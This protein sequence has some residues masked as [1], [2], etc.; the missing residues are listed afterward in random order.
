MDIIV[1]R[2]RLVMPPPTGAFIFTTVRLHY[3]FASVAA[4]SCSLH[5][6]NTTLSSW[7]SDF[8]FIIFGTGKLYC[9]YFASFATS[10]TS[11]SRHAMPCYFT[12]TSSSPI[13]RISTWT[14]STHIFNQAITI[15][16]Q[17]ATVLDSMFSCFPTN[18]RVG[19]YTNTRLKI[20]QIL[21]QAEEINSSTNE[22]TPGVIIFIFASEQ[23]FYFNNFKYFG[24]DELGNNINS[25]PIICLHGWPT[26][27]LP[28]ED[29]IVI[30]GCYI[31]IDWI[32]DIVI[33]INILSSLFNIAYSAAVDGKL[34]HHSRL[35]LLPL[36]IITVGCVCRRRLFSSSSWLVGFAITVDARLRLH[37]RFAFVTTDCSFVVVGRLHLHC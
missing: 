6:G 18:Q 9:C 13:F 35:S 20:W 33:F 24:L 19:G 15:R 11:T 27:Q 17:D 30:I 14:S 12:T 26:T 22:S 36:I 10:I 21:C 34:R 7:W 2:R 3:Q 16:R 4:D 28:I 29:L 25:P 8:I 5:Y 32:T 37:R 23:T 1:F 31:A